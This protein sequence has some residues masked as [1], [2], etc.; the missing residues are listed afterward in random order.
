MRNSLQRSRFE[1]AL[2]RAH[3]NLWTAQQEAEALG[4]LGAAEDITE[5]MRFVADVTA[6]SLK[7]RK[8]PRRQLSLLDS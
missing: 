2:A 1:A 6:D 7:G 3:R 4:D 5:V 8:R